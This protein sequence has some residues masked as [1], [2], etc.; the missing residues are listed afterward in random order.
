MRGAFIAIFLLLILISTIALVS[1][2]SEGKSEVVV[3]EDASSI[4]QAV[5]IVPSGGVVI[6]KSGVYTE[7]IYLNKSIEL[8]GEGM[9]RVLE[10]ITIDGVSNV[11][12]RGL[13]IEIYPPGTDIGISVLNSSNV[14]LEDLV[15]KGSGILIADSVNISI[16]N[17]SFVGNPGSAVR[18]T[19]KGSRDIVIER[20]VFNN[21]YIAL[22][23]HQGVNITFRY[24]AVYANR[25]AVKLYS[26]CRSSQIY[27]N[28][29]FRG[30]AEDN[31]LNNKWYSPELKLGNLWGELYALVDSDGDG[32]SDEPVEIDGV[33]GSIDPYPLINEFSKYFNTVSQGSNDRYT[34]VIAVLLLTVISIATLTYSYR[35]RHVK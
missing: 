32:V 31:G 28:N 20:S 29:F 4:N 19:G 33:A 1:G 10:S 9:P 11:A 2:G 7:Y 17:C 25:L 12:V 14:V 30:R 5:S 3:P 13:S 24:N 6:V 21:T 26:D 27:M 34:A 18:I 22:S 35:R 15:F 23:V 16:R 8:I